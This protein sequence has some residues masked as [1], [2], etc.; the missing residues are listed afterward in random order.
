MPHPPP[1]KKRKKNT[2]LSIGCV[3]AVRQ[4]PAGWVCPIGKYNIAQQQ[5][6]TCLQTPLNWFN[7]S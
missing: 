4:I 7:K 6:L 1:L 2:N 3:H 5:K